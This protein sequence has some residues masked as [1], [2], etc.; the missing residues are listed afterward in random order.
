MKAKK[1]FALLVGF[2]I[3]ACIGLSACGEGGGGGGG[4][5]PTPLQA[6]EI[7]LVG[8]E[9]KWEGVDH[10]DGYEVYEGNELVKQTGETSYTITQT[11]MGTYNYTVYA[12]STDSEHYSKSPVSNTVSYKIEKKTLAAPK[13]TLKGSTIS[14]KV[15][16]NAEKYEVYL[17]SGATPVSTQSETTYNIVQTS[18]G[19]YKYTVYAITTDTD[20]N[21]SKASNTV[22][23]VVDGSLAAPEVTLSG[24]VMSWE[25]V[26]D[27]VSYDI[28]EGT[29]KL[30]NQ[31]ETTFTI[32]KAEVGTYYFNV[33][34][35]TDD[36]VNHK[37]SKASNT[38]AYR[39]KG[40]D[41]SVQLDKKIY[42]VGDSTVCSF[43][44]DYYLPRYG[45]GTQLFNYL[46]LSN[47][48]NVVNLAISGRSSLSFLSETNY[49][50]LKNGINTGD[51]LIIGFGHN[52]EKSDDAARFTEPTGDYKTATVG[53]KPS[54]QY[55]LYEYYV[56]LAKEKGA[57]PI[58]CT[59]IV[60]YS[61]SGVYDGKSVAHVTD[62][63]D[64]AAAIK[65]LGADT[66]TAV[67]D[68][69]SITKEYYKAHNEDAKYFHAYTTYDGEKPNET[70]DGM[71]GTHINMYGAKMIAFWF[72]TNLPADCGLAQ[73]VKGDADVPQ[74]NA[75]YPAAIK[76]DYVKPEYSGFN[77]AQNT[78]FMTTTNADTVNWY[79]TAFGVLG[80]NKANNYVFAKSDDGVTITADSGSKFSSTGDGFGAVFVQ[81]DESM[82]FTV[83]AKA[84]VIS[85]PDT[86]SDQNA[87][88]IMLRDDIY[89]NQE[90]KTLASNFASASVTGKGKT[91]MSRSEKTALAYDGKTI[92]FAKDTEYEFTLE[93]TGQ[94]I[95]STVKQGST[96][97]TTTLTDVS[98]VGVDYDYMYVCLFANRS[99]KV[100][101]SDISFEY[102]GESQG[103]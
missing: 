39:V 80:G 43:N 7:H 91:N 98:Y 37:D 83:K 36:K 2:I 94:V 88:G 71:D 41:E 14:W 30:G 29:N 74:F 62:K 89:I 10:A 63:G 57:T 32:E 58:L 6:P 45:Y 5:N 31:T 67:V 93:R 26:P 82:N 35:I 52:D 100:Q 21:K 40:V 76:A 101:F 90:E 66:D 8:N 59:P 51:Y 1:F 103:A 69:T 55:T 16:P 73:H 61:E 87:F 42:V 60:R 47:A 22:E 96:V 17:N 56:K 23:Y 18:I 15:V 28:F 78:P 68:L 20:F 77:P 11:E 24:N 85:A 54:F 4:N 72:A 79:K 3:A 44:D 84:K 53:G 46:N 38:V 102:T 81:V 12:T 92:T 34:A 48:A 19:T 65:K 64:Y 75:D 49:T 25:A 27:A 70:A 95:K 13:L 86:V 9:L 50:I 33:F 97:I 99:L